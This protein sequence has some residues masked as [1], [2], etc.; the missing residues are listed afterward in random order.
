MHVQCVAAGGEGTTASLAGT[1]AFACETLASLVYWNRC[2]SHNQ[3][4][5]EMRAPNLSRTSCEQRGSDGL[6]CAC[7]MEYQS[8]VSLASGAALDIHRSAFIL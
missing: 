1:G 2:V 8:R 4:S 6:L 7:N 5:R 3:V